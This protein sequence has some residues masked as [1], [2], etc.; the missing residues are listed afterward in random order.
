MTD[1]RRQQL[2]DELQQRAAA[3]EP[4]TEY[5]GQPTLVG[6]MQALIDE[7]VD[8]RLELERLNRD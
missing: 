3:A 6:W 8:L 4:N 1:E 5:P 7:V 2:R